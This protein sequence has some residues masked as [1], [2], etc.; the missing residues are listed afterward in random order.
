MKTRRLLGIGAVTTLLVG[1]VW[2]ALGATAPARAQDPAIEIRSNLKATDRPPRLDEPLFLLALG[3]DA[4]IGNPDDALVDAL[5]IIGIDPTSGRAGILGIPR[6]A[7]VE[8]PG[9]GFAKINTAASLGGIDLM[10]ATVEA[11]SGCTFAH[12]VLTNFVGF[13]RMIDAIGGV[14]L[15]V[16]ERLYEEGRSNIDLQPGRQVLDGEQS[17]AWNRLRYGSSRPQG[18][19]SRSEAQNTFLLAALRE[20]RRD[21]GSSPGSLVRILAAVRRNV[22]H[23]LEAS[24]MLRLGQAFLAIEPRNVASAVVDGRFTTVNGSSIVQITTRGQ[25][26]FVD[27]CGDGALEP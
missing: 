5:H 24:E 21:F 3:G 13:E 7:Y 19:I 17:L 6:D 1:L 15:E 10:T 16:P 20:A 22:H 12:T 23:D 4:R 14:T 26:Q 11:M 9:H 27:L 2:V 18:D 8:I 25:E